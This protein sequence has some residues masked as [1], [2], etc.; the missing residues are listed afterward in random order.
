MR[1]IG[2]PD[3]KRV[4]VPPARKCH[5]D[6]EGLEPGRLYRCGLGAGSDSRHELV[7]HQ[8][9]ANRHRPVVC[10]ASDEGAPGAT[11]AGRHPTAAVISEHEATIGNIGGPENNAQQTIG[12]KRLTKDPGG[13]LR[14]QDHVDAQRSSPRG[15]INEQ[16]RK[17][18]VRTQ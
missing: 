10:R 1:L 14:A 7:S 8:R 3:E 2:E 15:E 13:A 5:R 6:R 11:H 9:D 16:V 4:V 17:L 12:Q 18:A